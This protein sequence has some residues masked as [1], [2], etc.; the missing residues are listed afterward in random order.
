LA[1]LCRPESGIVMPAAKM[2]AG[3][4]PGMTGP[5][6]EHRTRPR[7]RVPR[8][9]VEVVM[10]TGPLPACERLTGT[11]WTGSCRMPA[12]RI[13]ARLN[14]AS[15]ARAAA[16]QKARCRHD[17]WCQAYWMGARAQRGTVALGLPDD[18][19]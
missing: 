15:T 13:R 4:A 14:G 11:P 8:M 9:V 3:C 17:S 10:G 12:T 1:R 16:A 5:T 7:E 2:A 19:R 6:S 18:R